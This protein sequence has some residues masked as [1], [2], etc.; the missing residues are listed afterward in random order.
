MPTGYDS[1]HPTSEVDSSVKTAPTL[2]KNAISIVKSDLWKDERDLIRL[3]AHLI[4]L[5]K[6]NKPN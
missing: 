6:S 4:G 5:N 3:A 1:L 2:G